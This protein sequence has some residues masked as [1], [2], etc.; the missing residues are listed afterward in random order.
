MP[1]LLV[2]ASK[3]SDARAGH[4]PEH[5]SSKKTPSHIIRQARILMRNR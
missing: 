5:I 4:E 1:R 2:N 3:N